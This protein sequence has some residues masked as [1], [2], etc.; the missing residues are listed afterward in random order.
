MKKIAIISR[1]LHMN[2]ATKALVEML[3]RIDYQ[4]VQID[5]YVLDFSN[6]AE[7]WVAKIP[8]EVV[9]KKIPQYELSKGIIGTVIRRPVHFAKALAAGYKLRHEKMMIKQWKYT[10]QRLPVIQEKYDVAISFRHFDIDVF[11]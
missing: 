3:R 8:K 1:A 5:L 2:G 4:T 10:A 9:I 11:M 6:M 7:E